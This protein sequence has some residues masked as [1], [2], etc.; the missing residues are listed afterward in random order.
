MTTD[1]ITT[2]TA[3]PALDPDATGMA[4][5]RGRGWAAIRAAG[6]LVAVEDVVML[7]RREDVVA[8]L[9]CPEAFSSRGAFDQLGCPLPMVP[10]S[11]D[12]P[13]HTRYRK[14]LQPH[15]SPRALAA[16]RPSLTDQ[17]REL[18]RRLAARGRC[19]AVADLAVPY[20]S[21]VF[22][23]MF[24]FPLTDRDR[25]IR[26]KDAAI[27][28]AS[29]AHPPAEDVAAGMELFVYI[30]GAVAARRADPG[31]DLLSAVLTGDDPLSDEE[32]VG[33]CFTMV[34]AGLDTVTGSLGFAMWKL[35]TRPD[36]RRA[37]AADPARIPEF[38]E[39]LLRLE[40]PIPGIPR[41]T[42]REV[43]VGG[44][45]DPVEIPRGTLVWLGLGAANRE[46]APADVVLDP[47]L[48]GSPHAHH[49]AFGGG[50]HRCLGS[51]LAR[52]ELRLV[53]EAWLAEVPEFE[54]VPGTRPRITYPATTFS[55]DAL[56]LVYPVG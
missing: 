41:M 36:L 42:T 31:T 47:D 29:T 19:D 18:A 52:L 9:R 6:P 45:D 1:T 16:M 30:T 8:A 51:H 33:L 35:A 43:R 46:D 55:F 15:F 4:E 37:L 25:L 23:T 32:A 56:P 5:D 13:D 48:D 10:I 24:G 38:V 27:R 14:I 26:W 53:L 7:T 49:W 11:Y 28:M 20:P 17:A 2:H 21:Q 39:Q 40:G 50:P 22:L 44:T 12:P 3:P 54:L 34:L